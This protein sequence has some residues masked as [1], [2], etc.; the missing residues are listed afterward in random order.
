MK[1]LARR[2]ISSATGPQIPPLPSHHHHQCLHHYHH[3]CNC[4][5]L[6]H[7]CRQ[8]LP[9]LLLIIIIMVV[10][11]LWSTAYW[12]SHCILNNI[13]PHARIGLSKYLKFII[14]VVSIILDKYATIPNISIVELKLLFK[15]EPLKIRSTIASNLDFF[16]SNISI[17]HDTCKDFT[18]SQ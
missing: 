15:E 11:F 9:P 14:L 18:L 1:F 6:C 17:D 2:P 4:H 8:V 12:V 7:H 3:H 13:G 10:T 16:C 5:C